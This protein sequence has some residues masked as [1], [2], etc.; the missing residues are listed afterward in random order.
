MDAPHGQETAQDPRDLPPL[1]REHPR[2]AGRRARPEVITGEQ[3]DGKLSCPVWEGADE[4]GLQ[5]STSPVAYF[6]L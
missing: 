3:G 5:Q 4:K 2:R 1:P 6:T